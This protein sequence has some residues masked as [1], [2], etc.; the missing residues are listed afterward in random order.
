MPAMPFAG[1]LEALGRDLRPASLPFLVTSNSRMPR[2]LPISH[3]TH[4]AAA[5]TKQRASGFLF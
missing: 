1:S 2:R 3:G 5:I 4:L